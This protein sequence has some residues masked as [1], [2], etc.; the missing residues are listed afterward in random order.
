MLETLNQQQGLEI[1]S[2]T[3]FSW[4]GDTMDYGMAIDGLE[5][6]RRH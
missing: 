1:D 3:V 6:H 4:S 5:Q 2:N